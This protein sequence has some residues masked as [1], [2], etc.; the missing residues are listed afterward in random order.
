MREL[1]LIG[2]AASG[3]GCSGPE[4]QEE[5]RNAPAFSVF[6]TDPSGSD[7]ESGTEARLDAGEDLTPVVR[8]LTLEP[9]VPTSRARMRAHADISGRW[10]SVEYEWTING[11]RYGSNSIEMILPVIETGDTVSV[12]VVPIRGIERGKAV[13]ASVVA[14]NQPPMML[15]L[16]IEL[17]PADGRGL[18][19]DREHW[20][21]VARAE[22]PDGDS[23]EFEYRWLVNG[24]RSR[25]DEEVFPVADLVRGDRLAVEVRAYDGNAWSLPTRSGEIEIG[26]VPPSIVSTPPAVDAAGQFRYQ[27]KVEDADGDSKFRFALRNAPR[28]MRIDDVNGI[29]RWEPDAGQAGRH[30]VEIVVTD[31]G[32]AEATQSFSLALIARSDSESGVPAAPR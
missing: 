13:T 29:V 9:S 7:A 21:A 31:E 18:S 23:V 17:A 11:Q 10:S 8:S 20:R 5:E 4:R 16:G 25:V 6:A 30:E 28:G 26:N 27:V 1:I 14:K 12:R 2:L 24:E 15:G 22:D 3:A 19:S 32:G